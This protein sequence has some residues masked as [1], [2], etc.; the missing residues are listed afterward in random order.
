MDKYEDKIA[1][2]I[3]KAEGTNNPHEAETFMAK[4]EAMMLEHGIERAHLEAKSRPGD[5]VQARIKV[6]NGHGYAT[7][8][9]RIAHFIAPI[10]EV[11]SFRVSLHDGG[12][13][14]ILVGHKGDVDQVETLATSLMEQARKQAIHWWKTEG[15]P[16]HTGT[17][18]DAYLARREFIFAFAS[19][20]NDRLQETRSRVVQEAA[21]GTALVLVERAHLVDDWVASNMQVGKARVTKRRAGSYEAGVAGKQAG[22]DAVGTKALK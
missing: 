19:G 1:K 15:K 21:T 13:V 14:I 20:V 2:L 4:A 18:N 3:A 22:R 11:R 7:A 8:M 5:I 12:Q 10:F 9:A 16:Y 6:K 17:D